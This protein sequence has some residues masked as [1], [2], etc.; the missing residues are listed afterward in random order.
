MVPTSTI[1]GIQQAAAKSAVYTITFDIRTDEAS[2]TG[3]NE[4]HL[5]HLWHIGQAN[6]AEFGD[7]GAGSFAE[8]IGREIIRR[9]IASVPPELWAHQGKDCL[10]KQMQRSTAS[11]LEVRA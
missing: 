11:A 9:W 8:K 2:L 4:R 6:P 3:Y 5:A 7:A 10:H 1:Q